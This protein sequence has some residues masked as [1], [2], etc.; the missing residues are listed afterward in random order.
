M[1]Y[2]AALTYAQNGWPIFP[3]QGKIPYE[4][5]TPGVK[6]HGHKNATTDRQAIHHWWSIH[7]TANIGL[8]TGTVSGIIVVDIDPRHNGHLSIKELEKRHEPL[9]ATR[10]SRTAH[11]GLHRFYQHPNDG[12]SYPNAV[13][14]DGLSGI[15]VRGDGGYVVLPPSLL[16]GRLS[17]KWGNLDLPIASAPQW[18]LI[19]LS[20][21]GHQNEQTPHGVRFAPAVGEKWLSEALAKANEGNRNRVGFDL[22]CQLRDDGLSEAEARDILLTYAQAAPPGKTPYTAREALASVRSAYNRPPRE[23]AR[24]TPP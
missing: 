11:G 19:L 14:L 21:Q 6:S 13:E 3:L 5:L 9:P 22:A 16:Y 7:P 20:Q 1:L 8:A 23:K 18:L 4:Y 2:Q 12:K 15:D 17:Y 24:R 10:T